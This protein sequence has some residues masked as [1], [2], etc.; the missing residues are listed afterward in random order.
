MAQ[1]A[2]GLHFFLQLNET[3]THWA[4]LHF[5]GVRLSIRQQRLLNGVNLRL[6][7]GL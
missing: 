7:K 2:A 6:N 1:E 3:K 4:P 5:A